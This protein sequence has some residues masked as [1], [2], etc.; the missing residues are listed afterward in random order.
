MGLVGGVW[1]GSCG[2]LVGVRCCLLGC[3]G[4]WFGGVCSVCLMV[5]V[6]VPDGQ[7]GALFWRRCY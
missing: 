7:F 6:L 3:W 4:I 5:C 1:V 2:L